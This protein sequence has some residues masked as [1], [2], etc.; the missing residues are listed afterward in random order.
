MGLPYIVV[1][2]LGIALTYLVLL[3]IILFKRWQAKSTLGKQIPIMQTDCREEY[4]KA[5]RILRRRLAAVTP[6]GEGRKEVGF[7]SSDNL[8][9]YYPAIAFIRLCH[10]NGYEVEIRQRRKEDSPI[11]QGEIVSRI[12]DEEW[13]QCTNLKEEDYL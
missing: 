8:S 4:S 13:K 12:N 1:F 3:P 7:T 6:M 2:F 5:I 11:E 10:L 9:E